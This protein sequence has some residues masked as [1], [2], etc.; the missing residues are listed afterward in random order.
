[1]SVVGSCHG[2]ARLPGKLDKLRQ[3]GSILLQTVILQFDVVIL[4][5]EQI[6]IPQ[7]SRLCALVVP[8]QNGLR[9]LARKTGRKADQSLVVLLQ[10]LLIHTG[11]GIKALHKPG[12]DHFD[13]V[14]ITGLVF[15]QQNQVVVAVDF[16]YLIKAGAGGNIHFA[17]DDGLDTRL[18]SGFIKLHTAVHHAVVGAGNG[19]LSTLLHPLHQLID[20]AGTVQ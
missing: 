9:D 4:C 3:N 18:F 11:L 6:P 1:M 5:T 12:R 14:L 7:R 19:S 20:A 8:C 17:P 16:I 2:D 10:K 15:A 13:Q